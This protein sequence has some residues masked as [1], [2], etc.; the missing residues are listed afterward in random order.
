LSLPKASHTEKPK[1]KESSQNP[2]KHKPQ[3]PSK[4]KGKG[5]KR[6]KKKL[7]P[8]SVGLLTAANGVE[9]RVLGRV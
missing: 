1:A 7:S 9:Q 3:K 5:K 8:P 4:A 6:K 2:K